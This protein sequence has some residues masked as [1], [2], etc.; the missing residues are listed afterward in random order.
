MSKN[1]FS[2]PLRW[3]LLGVAAWAG[4]GHAA[5]AQKPGIKLGQPSASRLATHRQAPKPA[6]A[7]LRTDPKAR[8]SSDLQRLYTAGQANRS[9][10]TSAAAANAAFPLLRFSKD[11]TA[12]MVHI[13]AQNVA[14]LLPNLQSR[15]FVVAAA[16]PTLHFVEGLLPLSQLAAGS[17]GV[18]ALTTQGLLGVVPAYRPQSRAG[19]ITSQGDYAMEVAR[20]RATRPKNLDGSGVRVGVLSDSFNSQNGAATDISTGDLPTNGVQVL[21]DDG[22]TDEGRAMCQIAHDLAPGSPLAFSTAN[23]SEAD[24]A[25]QIIRLADPAQG[26]CK[27]IVDD[28]GYFLEP[29]FQDG[30]IAQAITQ[31]VGQGVAY[32]SS[33]GNNANNSYENTT[34]AFVNDAQGVG[35]LNFSTTGTPDLTQRFVVSDGYDLLL[36]L[37][38]SDPFYTSTGVKTDLDMYLVKVRPS[39]VVQKGDTVASSTI[40]NVGFQ[41]PAEIIGFSNDSSQ[42]HTTAFDLHIVRRA[43]TANPTRLKYIN[44]LNGLPATVVGPT[45]WQT[46]SG[47][48]VGHPA[49]VAAM[50]VAAVP[51]YSPRVPEPYTSLGRPTILFAPN[52]TALATPE[53]RQKPNFAAADGVNTS[54]FGTSADDLEGDG[55]PNFFGT[56]AAAPHAAGIAAL[57]RQSEPNLTPAQVYA[58]LTSTA[59]LLGA[60]TADLQTGAGLIDAFTAIYGP[61]VAITPPAVEDLEK[62]ALPTSWTVSSTRGGRVQVINTLNPASGTQHLLLDS[63]PGITANALNEVVW[64]LRGV[65][66]SSALLTFRERKFAAETDQVM[67]AQFTGSSN[68][69]GV[70]LSVDGGTTW[71]RVFDLTGT[72]A[73]TTY[74]TKSVSLTQLATANGLTL[75]NDV[76]LKF[77]QYGTGAATGNTASSRA[78]R[79]F[80]DIAVTGLTPAPVALYNSTQ[81]LIGCPGLTVQYADS[82][83]FKPTSY[84]W[85][86]AGGTPATS[87]SRTPAV[88]YNT[89]GHYAVTLS[90]TNANGTVARTDTGYV[91]VYGRAPLATVTTTNASICPGGTVTFGSTAAYCPGTYSWSFPGGSPATSSAQ[92]PGV[93]TY[94][95]AGNYVATLTVS[96]AY[97]S[98]TT[99]IAV[100]VGGRALPFTET[101]DNTANSQ[102]LPAGWSIV[103][104][105]QGVTWQIAEGIIGRNGQAS[106]ALRAPFWFDSNVGEHDAVYTPAL[107][108]VGRTT[109]TLLFDVAYG[110]V[111][112]NQ[113]DSLTVQIADACTGAILGKPYAKGSAGTLPTTSPKDEAIFLPAS[114]ADWRQERVDLTPYA[115]K[116]VVIR[117]VGRNGFG[118]YL[119][120]DNVQV[121]NNLLALTTAAT[122]VG[123]EAWPNPTPAGSSL[124]VTLPAYSGSVSLRLFDNLGRVVWQ[125]QVQQTG[126]ALE[127]TLSLPVATGLY[128]LVYTPATGTP[129]ARRIVLE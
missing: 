81:P 8:L 50:A 69:D 89:P 3:A 125:E 20:S 54:S 68:T 122:A 108:L 104:P 116:S 29:F 52:G 55:F 62:G 105:D 99:N 71:Y 44:E 18:G 98:T 57:L 115:G 114:G 37:Q 41:Y 124:H 10:R 73:T 110:K 2:P 40:D 101:F 59:R 21:L 13:T 111:T 88:V 129:A 49:A 60:T 63:Y 72:N 119:Y 58:R 109:P 11:G 117:F 91:F 118:Q 100:A 82:S 77:Q 53:V 34:P 128:N 4:L 74:Q 9:L 107:S 94:A 17:Q 61:A 78:G 123:L 87:T 12:V 47:T 30:I 5:L 51:Y 27:V 97:G 120:L 93:V 66:A 43:G 33:A 121:G 45:E 28:V 36:P 85:T 42:T 83:L 64:Y 70:A 103:N 112:D 19:V 92:N 16:Y 76:R 39:G 26:N 32:F 31:V 80:D 102:T 113:L 79:V 14:A 35:R 127:R 95:A 15:G 22:T 24:F 48:L 23:V 38:W 84:A 75:G 106:R 46:N 6:I 126:A 96:N 90:V 56:S 86:F 7:A 25:N 65:S 67:P 1:V